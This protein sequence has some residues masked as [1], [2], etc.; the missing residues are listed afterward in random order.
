MTNAQSA[1]LVDANLHLWLDPRGAPSTAGMTSY[2]AP[3]LDTTIAFRTDEAGS[4]LYYTTAF[5]RVSATG[6][7]QTASYGKVTAT[8][9]QRLSYENTNEIQGD[10]E[11]QSVNQTTDAYSGVHV[12]AGRGVAYSQEAQQSFPL[13]MY[14]GVASEAPNGS[15]TVA[16]H[17]RQGFAEER[18]AA[19]RSGLFWSRSLSNAQECAVDVDMD[20]EGDAVGVSWGTRQR[21]VYEASDGCYSRDVT[22]SGYDIVSDHSDEVCV[23]GA[24]SSS[25]SRAGGARAVPDEALARMSS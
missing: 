23:K 7:V 17:V 13:Y 11:R 14:V 9:K 4:E 2:D 25:S 10:D 19:G 3:P 5:R 15:Y 16:R 8:W 24:S 6:W 18:A 1:W 21:Y 12:T 22:S 20:D